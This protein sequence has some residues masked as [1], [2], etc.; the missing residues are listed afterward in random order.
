MTT[1]EQLQKI[2]SDR[3]A[4]FLLLIDPDNIDSKNLPRFIGEATKAG[5]DAFLVGGS[6]MLSNE[7][8]KTLKVIKENTNAPV[9]IFP[10][11]VSQVS[12]VADAILFLLLISGRNP[13]YLIGNQVNAAPII[14]RMKLEAISTGY[15]LIE[16]GNVTSAEF[17]S[18]TKPIPRE[19]PDIAVAHALAAELIGLK[20]LYLEA[21]SGARQSVPD[22]M[23][24]KVTTTCSLPVI[25]GG[26]IRTPEEARNK[27]NAGA[28]FIV[29]GT[30]IEE[31]SHKSLI[32]EF[33]DAIHTS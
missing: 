22:A 12:S 10:G 29:T 6:L 4:G 11:G 31:N 26:G 13:D 23:I 2:K 25:V 15:M 9:I 17:M 19:K 24:K 14:K 21:G 27:V 3:G 32:Q 33:A 8:D 1:F 16:G 28:S 20:M 18:N 7:F 30:I 5:T